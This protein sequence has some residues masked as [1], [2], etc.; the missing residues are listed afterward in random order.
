MDHQ[1]IKEKNQKISQEK[2]KTEAQLNKSCDSKSSFQTE[3]YSDT[4]LP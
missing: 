4:G 2:M 1:E 3:V